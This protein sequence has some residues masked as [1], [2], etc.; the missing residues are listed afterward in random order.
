MSQAAPPPEETEKLVEL[1]ISQ[2]S[3]MKEFMATKEDLAKQETRIAEKISSELKPFREMLGQFKLVRWAVGVGIL[4]L[5]KIA[6]A[7]NLFTYQG[8]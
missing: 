8:Q 1:S 3:E 2:L 6:F 5:V 4:L 7:P